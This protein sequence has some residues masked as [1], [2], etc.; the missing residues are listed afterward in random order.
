MRMECAE[1]NEICLFS[2]AFLFVVYFSMNSVRMTPG[3]VTASDN[4]CHADLSLCAEPSP[5]KD[6]APIIET[7]DIKKP[8]VSSDSDI[9]NTIERN[10]T[11]STDITP[12][13]KPFD[14]KIKLEVSW[15]V[16]IF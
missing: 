7:K 6:E 5:Q 11:K 10:E 16:G 9:S 14:E 2:S 8:T 3:K 12:K 1:W 15:V 13:A 4:T